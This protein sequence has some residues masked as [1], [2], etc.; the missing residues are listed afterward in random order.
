VSFFGGARIAIDQFGLP[1]AASRARVAQCR[2]PHRTQ[3][4]STDGSKGFKH[5]SGQP[6][7]RTDRTTAPRAARSADDFGIDQ[8]GI[9]DEFG[10][11]AAASRK[12]IRSLANPGHRFGRS[13]LVGTCL[14][15]DP[16]YCLNS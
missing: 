11:E 9:A 13:V 1:P 7:I 8:V 15:R 2:R 4:R 5:L 10:R 12:W 6:S 3:Y 14:A 16:G